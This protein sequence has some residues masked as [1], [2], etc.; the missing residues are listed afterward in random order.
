MSK[1]IKAEA[2]VLKKRSLLGKDMAVTFFTA[3][4][5]KIMAV[6]KGVKKIT[7]RRASHIQTGNLVKIILYQKDNRY[8]LQES[9]LISAFS[10]IKSSQEKIDFQ[11]L[12]FFIID[13]LLPE[14]QK[15]DDVYAFTKS[16]LLDLAKTSNF[17]KQVMTLYLRKL[18]LL[19]GYHKGAQSY[20]EQLRYVEEI[21]HEK[22]PPSII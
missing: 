9:N 17:T 19:L 15:E 7:S 6:A 11:Y 21:I 14:R 4:E 12:F 22:I 5:G 13:R 3:T 2:V 18:L 20:F 16:F 10:T 8:Y 1:T